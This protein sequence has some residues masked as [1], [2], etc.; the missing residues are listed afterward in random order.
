MATASMPA[1]LHILSY[2]DS[3]RGGGVE[4]AM[5]RLAAGWLDLD[6]QVTLAIGDRAGPLA[7]ELPPGARLAAGSLATAVRAASPD[8]VFCPGNHYTARAAL[9]RVQ[10]GRR[11]PPIVAKMSNALDRADL[12]W[13]LRAGNRGWLR[14]HPW[15][16][17]RLVAMTP[18]LAADTIA[19]TGIAPARV[20]VIP[21]PP[22]RA[23]PGA[24]SMPVP[25]GDFVIGVGRLEPQK[26]WDRL[27]SAIPRLADTGAHVVI[28]GEG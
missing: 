6:A 18:T 5:L 17:A 11:C 2:A 8:I 16:C 10:Q 4:R 26:R 19:A 14:M 27:V 24:P 7:A 22:A 20:T 9:L 28:V 21:N 23:V 15:F 1:P 12:A 25:P 3:L 13:P